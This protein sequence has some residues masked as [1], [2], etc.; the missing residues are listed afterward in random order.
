MASPQATL[1]VSRTEKKDVGHREIFVSL[2]GERVGILRHGDT[3]SRPITPGHHTIR[4]HN[5]LFFKSHEFD[6]QPGEE[7]RFT[8]V[9]RAGWGSY[10]V[11]AW[12]GAGPLY[13]TF[14]RAGSP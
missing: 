5:T 2:D 13:L 3:I 8:A 4:A 9:N 14:E 10:S 6:A 11:L 1:V 7:V 12:I